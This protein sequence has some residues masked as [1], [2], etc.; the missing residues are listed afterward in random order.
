MILSQNSMQSSSSLLFIYSLS[1]VYVYELAF[2]YSRPILSLVWSGLSVWSSSY[3]LRNNS[4]GK[5]NAL[6]VQFNKIW[7]LHDNHSLVW[8]EAVLILL[9]GSCA[10]SHIGLCKITSILHLHHLQFAACIDIQT[11]RLNSL[12][13]NEAL[14]I[15]THLQHRFFSDVFYLW[16]FIIL[17]ATIISTSISIYFFYLKQLRKWGRI[18]YSP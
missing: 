10:F 17:Q 11:Y 15:D 4:G 16:C 8:Q 3:N 12:I 14:C 5:C 6:H 1:K 7:M 13:Q 2:Q 9:F 18:L